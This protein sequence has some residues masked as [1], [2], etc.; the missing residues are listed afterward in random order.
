[1]YRRKE[2]R[3]SKWAIVISCVSLLSSI[4]S[5]SYTIY[6]DVERSRENIYFAIN[7]NYNGDFDTHLISTKIPN[8]EYDGEILGI[9]PVNY[10]IMLANNGENTVSIFSYDLWQ[11]DNQKPIQ[12]SYLNNG[13]Y[14]KNE[15]LELPITIEPGKSRK[16]TIKLG[17][18]VKDFVYN[19]LKEE[20]KEGESINFNRIQE[21]LLSKNTDLFGNKVEKN[22]N[23][24]Y[25]T[26]LKNE[27]TYKLS[28]TTSKGTT[29]EKYFNTHSVEY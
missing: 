8:F 18:Q 1:M 16:I 4:I 12:F 17:I 7:S 29:F 28:F 24:L 13:L 25:S 20:F 26:D 6:K 19:I 3:Y 23:N 15:L 10:E 11:L 21:T 5:I 9:L 2:N 22:T 14:E 27:N